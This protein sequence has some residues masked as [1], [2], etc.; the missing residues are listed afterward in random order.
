M[1]GA[2][3]DEV[4]LVVR[5]LLCHHRLTLH[6]VERQCPRT[7]PRLTGVQNRCDAAPIPFQDPA[8]G[9]VGY[10]HGVL[11]LQRG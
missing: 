11:D 2:D 8:T 3:D 5:C 9:S 7:A 1:A 6:V 4:L 10:G